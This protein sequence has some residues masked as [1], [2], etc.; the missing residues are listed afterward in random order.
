MHLIDFS[1]SR[2]I[3]GLRCSE[4]LTRAKVIS[5]ECLCGSQYA[6]TRNYT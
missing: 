1:E 2:F 6:E 5:L 3:A 4:I